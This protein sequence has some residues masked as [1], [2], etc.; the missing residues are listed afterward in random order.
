MVEL[1]GSARLT[2]A[3][4]TFAQS[5]LGQDTSARAAPARPAHPNPG[6]RLQLAPI[7][8]ILNSFRNKGG[9]AKVGDSLRKVVVGT[10][11]LGLAGSNVLKLTCLPLQTTGMSPKQLEMADQLCAYTE[12]HHLINPDLHPNNGHYT[13]FKLSEW[14][15]VEMMELFTKS[16]DRTPWYH[17]PF[18]EFLSTYFSTLFRECEIVRSEHG[19][20]EAY[21]SMAFATDFVPGVVMS[22][23]FAQMQL[24]SIPLKLS[25][26]TYDPNVMT[27][28]ILMTACLPSMNES[29]V[30]HYFQHVVDE[31]ICDASLLCTSHDIV[32]IGL[33]RIIVPTFKT[34]GEI[35]VQI[36]E[37]LPS[38][39]ILQISNQKVVQ[40]SL[41]M[42]RENSIQCLVREIDSMEGLQVMFHYQ[43]PQESSLTHLSVKVQ[44][45]SL[46]TLTRF[47][48]QCNDVRIKQIYDFWS[49]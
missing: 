9:A 34:M 40:V 41:E 7:R 47:V 12:Q 39:R 21:G 29:G 22:F 38:A 28:E 33:Y 6:G 17:F 8:D 36:G 11:S 2:T 19:I 14:M 25:L 26:P 30:L 5:L 18:F 31:R 43:Y 1:R 45:S 46:L 49:G 3:S 4:L 48:A 10:G 20:L 32:K 35:L 24:L 15:Q 13:W 37:C 42:S 23:L 27:E 44:V 16:L